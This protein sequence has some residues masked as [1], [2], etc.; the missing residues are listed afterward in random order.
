MAILTAEQKAKYLD[1]GAGACPFC[2][3]TDISGDGIQ[4]EG[5]ECWQEVFCSKCRETWR[6]VYKL[7]FVETD[8]E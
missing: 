2:G 3:D 6:D 8:D 5:T 7:A 1:G 4:I